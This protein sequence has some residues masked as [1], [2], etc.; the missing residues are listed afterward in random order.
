MAAIIRVERNVFTRNAATGLLSL[1]TQTAFYV[2]NIALTAARAAEAIRAHWRIETTFHYS[3]ESPSA[4]MARAS[5]PILACSPACAASTSS[6]RTEP[7][8]SIRTAAARLSQAST[9][10]SQSPGSQSVE[11]P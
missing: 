4:R 11:Q 8:P 6:R 2:S 1:S 5:A 3:R 10:C 7:T 9:T